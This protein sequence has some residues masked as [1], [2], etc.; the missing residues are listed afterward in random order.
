MQ[1][2]PSEELDKQS[3]SLIESFLTEA[4]PNVK[5][6]RNKK[7]RATLTKL[8]RRFLKKPLAQVS[9]EDLH[10]FIEKL[11][12]DDLEQEYAAWT[13]HDYRLV[14]KKFFGWLY[15]DNK[16]F[17]SW[18][19]IGTAETSVGPEDILTEAELS[20]MRQVCLSPR[21]KAMLETLYEA[22]PRPHEFLG[23]RRCDI[24]FEDQITTVHIEKGKTGPRSIP[25]VGDAIPALS[26]WD[27][28]HPRQERDAR[29]PAG[30]PL[31]LGAG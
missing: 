28:N 25:V 8:G 29:L 4:A 20:Q 26:N 6:L 3:K 7:Y 11:N 12:N 5:E 21:D 24:L 16:E 14:C 27:F 1:S 2:S 22:A 19:K 10:E 23:L 9:N 18:I 15:K 30:S 13:K 31:F 17:V